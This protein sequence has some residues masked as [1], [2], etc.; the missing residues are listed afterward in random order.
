MWNVMPCLVLLTY[1][2]VKSAISGVLVSMRG[3]EWIAY[4]VL[5]SSEN[6][7]RTQ[8]LE[9]VLKFKT[10]D[11]AALLIFSVNTF[12]EDYISLELLDGKLR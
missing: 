6:N 2:A 1:V 10:I 9:I 3:T 7:I 12:Q 5:Q 8:K 11:P 4:D